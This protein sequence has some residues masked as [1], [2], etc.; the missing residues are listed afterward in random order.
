M[1][2]PQP[3]TPQDLLVGTTAR[4]QLIDPER[5]TALHERT[6]LPAKPDEPTAYVGRGRESYAETTDALRLPALMTRTG[7]TL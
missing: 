1:S 7:G 2:A 5:D 6:G 3:V 4:V